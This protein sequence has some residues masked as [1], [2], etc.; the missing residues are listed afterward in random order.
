M[1]IVMIGSG[2]VGLVSGACL[3]DFGHEVFCVDKS[4]EKVEVRG[5]GQIVTP[6]KAG[7]RNQ[8]SR[9]NLKFASSTWAGSDE[10]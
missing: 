5:T 10:D 6:R 9:R 8:K 4:T 2:Y 7:A 1:R 3:A